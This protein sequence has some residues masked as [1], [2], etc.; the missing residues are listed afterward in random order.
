MLQFKIGFKRLFIFGFQQLDYNLSWMF[1]STLSSLSILDLQIH[2]SHEI[3]T[4]FSYYFFKYFSALSLFSSGIPTM[5]IFVHL[6]ESQRFLRL[7]SPF[8]LFFPKLY[9][10]SC[11]IFKF[12]NSSACLNLFLN[13]YSIFFILA[14]VFKLQIFFL[15]PFCNFYLFIGILILFIIFLSL[16]MSSFSYLLKKAS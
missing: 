1:Q 15:V 2:I 11:T 5:K 9:Y 14:V 16:S 3:Q 10:F 6:M 8:L 13:P 7:H 12:V 4:I